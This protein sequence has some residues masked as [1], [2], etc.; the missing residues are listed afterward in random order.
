MSKTHGLSRTPTYEIWKGMRKRCNNPNAISYPYYGGKGIKVCQRWE[1]F[2][3]F[4]SDMGER[5]DGCSIDRIDCLGDY[6]PSNCRWSTPK[7]QAANRGPRR[8]KKNSA[9]VCAF[10]KR[11]PIMSWSKDPRCRVEYQTLYTR[12]AKLGWSPELAIT[13]PRWSKPQPPE[14]SANTTGGRTVPT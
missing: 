5:P 4:L 14:H 12:I 6:E 10:G 9:F 1:R 3:N 8:H 2:E 11:Q 7:E 13:T